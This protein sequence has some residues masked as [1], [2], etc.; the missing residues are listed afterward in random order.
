LRA[1]RPPL[2][3]LFRDE[4]LA[5]ELFLAVLPPL[6]ALF[7]A[8]RPADLP[9]LRADFLLPRADFR[10]DRLA[11]PDLLAD[12]RRRG[13]VAVSDSLEDESPKSNE[14]EV[15]GVEGVL[16]EGRGSIHPEPDQPI[17]I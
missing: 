7:R 14:R 8:E 13:V 17:S 1:V 3:A 2:R 9:P 5:L 6:R 16:S 4:L 15:E 11:E 10:P 12:F